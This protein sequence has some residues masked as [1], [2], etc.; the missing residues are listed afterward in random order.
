[1]LPKRSSKRATVFISCVFCALLWLFSIPS[2]GQDNSPVD[3]SG[4]W[5]W[6]NQEDSTN[7][8]SGV[9]P[10]GRYEGLP[11]NDAARMRADT[12]SEEWLSTS[13][14][15][16]CRP[17]GPTYQPYGLDPMEIEKEVDPLSRQ[18][19]AYKIFF[20]KTPGARMIWLDGRPHPA[21]FLE[22]VRTDAARVEELLHL[23][24]GELA[25]LLFGVIDAAFL[26]DSRAD[27]LHDLF[28]VDRIGSNVE[29]GHRVVSGKPVPPTDR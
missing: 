17:R 27:L 16:Q 19:V 28:D 12:Y 25:D 9:D 8:L 11:L 15:L 5:R 1:M 14:L 21:I 20:Q 6:V 3:L 29:V 10:G 7:R 4:T 23:D 13:P 22:Q 18:I 2:F 26:A 24:G